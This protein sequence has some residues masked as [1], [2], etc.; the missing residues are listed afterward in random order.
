[1]THDSVRYKSAVKVTLVAAAVNL[2]MGITKVIV[3]YIGHSQVLI[4]D[5]MHSVS[6]LLTD[7]LVLWGSRYSNIAADHDHPYGHG[8]IETAVTVLLAIVL[9]MLGTS[10]IFG[11]TWQAFQ[12]KLNDDPSMSVLFIAILSVLSNEW[13]YRYTLKAA[14]R[15]DSNMLRA[16]AWH[17]RSDAASSI[18]AIIGIVGTMLG[19]TFLDAITATIVGGMIISMGW[20]LAWTS[21]QELIDSGLDANTVNA[22]TRAVYQVPQVKAIHQLRTRSMGGKILVDFHLIVPSNISVSEGH[23]IGE[24]VHLVLLKEFKNIFDV[25]VHIDPEDD[26]QTRPSSHLP[27]RD[28]IVEKLKKR[29]KKLTIA[30]EIEK[31]SLHYLAGQI[32]VEVYLSSKNYHSLQNIQELSKQLQSATNKIKEIRSVRCL[33]SI[34]N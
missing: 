2:L 31:I 32:D 30:V 7:A 21:I 9:I 20:K 26:E 22:I 34:D 27:S 28:D 29:W 1:M 11:A 15:I 17:H 8:R 10:I 13:L 24:Q 4:A 12:G 19:F 5:G 16:N 3:G 25:I 6:D 33:L 23:Y 18:V 14:N